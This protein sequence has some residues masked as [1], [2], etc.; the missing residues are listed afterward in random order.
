MLYGVDE[1]RLNEVLRDPNN[2]CKMRL[3][4]GE[5]GDS[6]LGYLPKGMKKLC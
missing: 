4:Y 2:R 1:I 6:A 5:S 3:T